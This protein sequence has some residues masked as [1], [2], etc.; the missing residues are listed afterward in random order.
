MQ[1]ECDCYGLSG[2]SFFLLHYQRCAHAA[3]MLLYVYVN[4][5]DIMHAHDSAPD[6]NG[7]LCSMN[8]PT[9]TEKVNAL[10]FEHCALHLNPS[11]LVEVISYGSDLITELFCAR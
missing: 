4:L 10:T 7:W 1:S 2:F 6:M 8:V 5:D 9:T 3:P 11:P